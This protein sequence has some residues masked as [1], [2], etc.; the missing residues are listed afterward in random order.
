MRVPILLSIFLL[1]FSNFGK[2]QDS[3]QIIF[4]EKLSQSTNYKKLSV[5]F[6]NNVYPDC[7][8]YG[9]GPPKIT[10]C[11]IILEKEFKCDFSTFRFYYKFKYNKKTHRI[12]VVD[13]ITQKVFS[14]ED[15]DKQK[16]K[17][18]D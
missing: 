5:F 12:K 10:K 8:C 17:G 6:C 18:F 14:V 15:W 1:Y 4:L 3:F 11:N 9:F 2:S 13:L 16:L 7:G